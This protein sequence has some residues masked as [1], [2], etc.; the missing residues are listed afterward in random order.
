MR[1]VKWSYNGDFFECDSAKRDRNLRKHRIDLV[2]A[3]DVFSDPRAEPEEDKEHSL[4]E[5]RYSIVGMTPSGVLL[6]V[7]YTI[8]GDRIRIIS[9]RKATKSEKND[10]ARRQQHTIYWP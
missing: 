8:R 7:S 10:Y 2:A 9:A 6:F 3:S 1:D 5:D 4:T